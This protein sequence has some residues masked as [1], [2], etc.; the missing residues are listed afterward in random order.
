MY[1]DQKEPYIDNHSPLSE[2]L[3]SDQMFLTNDGFDLFSSK[4]RM[5]SFLFG[6]I[7]IGLKTML[8][9]VKV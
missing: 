6:P 7:G 9:N 1:F 3:V 4:E 2:Y 5:R 8:T